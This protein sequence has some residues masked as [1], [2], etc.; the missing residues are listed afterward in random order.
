MAAAIEITCHD[1]STLLLSV[2]YYIFFSK[3]RYLCGDYRIISPCDGTCT[4][5]NPIFCDK[6]NVFV[7]IS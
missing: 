3:L 6:N 1:H 4:I 7:Q 5:T 2:R